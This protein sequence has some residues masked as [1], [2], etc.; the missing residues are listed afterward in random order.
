MS[1]SKKT[2]HSICK[3][4]CGKIIT[5]CRHIKTNKRRECYYLRN[6]I[7]EHIERLYQERIQKELDKRNMFS[8]AQDDFFDSMGD[9]ISKKEF[10]ENEVIYCR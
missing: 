4:K 7:T 3:D 8:M 5:K 6:K 10:Y 9:D 1:L 2:I